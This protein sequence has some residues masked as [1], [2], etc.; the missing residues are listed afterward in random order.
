[1]FCY[2]WHASRVRFKECETVNQVYI[3][4]RNRSDKT[5]ITVYISS[6][7][8]Y[9]RNHVGKHIKHTFVS[10]NKFQIQFI[11]EVT[12]R[13]IFLLDN[14]NQRFSKFWLFGYAGL[15]HGFIL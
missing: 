12:S 7:M 8:E 6:V 11:K 2:S 4:K 10:Y 15:V 9:N 14:K 3:R 5:K 1:M 13:F